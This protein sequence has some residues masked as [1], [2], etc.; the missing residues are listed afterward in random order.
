MPNHITNKLT[1]LGTDEEIEKVFEFLKGAPYEDGSPRLVDFN[2]IIPQPANMFHGGLS[3]EDRR[4]C[5][6]E[7]I[8]NWYDWNI[9][10]WGTK[11]GA[12]SIRQREGNSITF[13]TAWSFPEPV[14]Q[15]LAKIFPDIKM[16]WDWA[17]EDTGEN[18]GRS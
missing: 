9:K 5:S 12:Y 13:E 15:K 4:R 3:E 1:V 16:T 6:A 8:P 10:H 18:V 11:W 14:A 17:D 2:K 7:G